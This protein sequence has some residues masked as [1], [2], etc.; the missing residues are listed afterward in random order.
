[1]DGNNSIVDRTDYERLCLTLC[2]TLGIVTLVLWNAATRLRDC[3]QYCISGIAC[4]MNTNQLQGDG[5]FGVIKHLYQKD[6]KLENTG[7]TG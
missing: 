5:F 3:K 1:M 6:R 7:L 2:N 4:N